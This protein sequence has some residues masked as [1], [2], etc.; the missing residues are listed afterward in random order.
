MIVAADLVL[1]EEE[2]RLEVEQQLGKRREVA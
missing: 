2:S 1:Y